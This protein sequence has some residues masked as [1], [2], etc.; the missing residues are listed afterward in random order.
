MCPNSVNRLLTPRATVLRTPL[1]PNDDT[2]ITIQQGKVGSC[3]LLASLD[4]ILN[5]SLD[6][7]RKVKSM[8]TETEDGSVTVRIKRT[9]Y[10]KYLK[11]E[12]VSKKYQHYYDSE[13]DQDVFVI[14]PT[15]LDYIDKPS[16]GVRT[17]SLAVKII[18]RLSSYYYV[19]DYEGGDVF[20]SLMAHNSS[21]RHG[22]D[23]AAFVGKL[24]DVYCEKVHNLSELIKLKT[25]RPNQPVY[26]GMF[27]QTGRHG[28]RLDKVI[29]N[30]SSPCGYDVVLVNPWDNQKTEIYSLGEIQNRNAR[31]C[32]FDANPEAYRV[33]RMLLR[34]SDEIR[35]YVNAHPLLYDMLLDMGRDAFLSSTVRFAVRMHK[36]WPLLP[37]SYRALGEEHKKIVLCCLRDSKGDKKDFDRKFL[38]AYQAKFN[39]LLEAFELEWVSVHKKMLRCSTEERLLFK[40]LQFFSAA[41]FTQDEFSAETVAIFKKGCHDSIEKVRH[42][43]LQYSRLSAILQ[44]ILDVISAILTLVVSFVC[45][46]TRETSKPMFF[47]MP[48]THST[49]VL[50]KLEDDLDEQLFFPMTHI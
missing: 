16:L 43:L 18:E 11:P 50:K 35:G 24:L 38:M 45:P 47:S 5:T 6:G 34:C 39:A 17:N 23:A 30:P 41:F 44:A 48:E 40:R 3:Y 46:S 9:S 29:V 27:Y 36:Q 31:F 2:L 4:C 21:S 13:C 37:V 25:F 42:E 10:S 32:V 28:F 26:L 33:T 15:R 1:F 22:G 14:H 8:F 7:R 19:R 12:K 49:S 20:E